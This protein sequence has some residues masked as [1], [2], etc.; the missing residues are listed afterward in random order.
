MNIH[1]YNVNIERIPFEIQCTRTN[2]NTALYE[3]RLIN[4]N[5]FFASLTTPKDEKSKKPY[6]LN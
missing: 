2:V 1:K 4:V 5:I 6:N 3:H